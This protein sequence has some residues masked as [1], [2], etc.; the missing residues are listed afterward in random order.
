MRMAKFL[1]YLVLVLS[2]VSIAL[3]VY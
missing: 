2:G 1:E 3:L